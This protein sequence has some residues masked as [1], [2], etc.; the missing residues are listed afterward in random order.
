[1]SRYAKKRDKILAIEL[2][3]QLMRKFER[4]TKYEPNVKWFEINN[5][6]NEPT[7]I[8]ATTAISKPI[9][10]HLN[11]DSNN[12]IYENMEE[13]LDNIPKLLSSAW[14]PVEPINEDTFIAI[15]TYIDHSGF[16]YLHSKTGSTYI[17]FKLTLLKDTT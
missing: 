6:S 2:K 4:L 3:R 11:S 9:L 7:E 17:L 10:Y 14:L 15:P 8:T 1:M 13:I 5:C 12:Q 16:L